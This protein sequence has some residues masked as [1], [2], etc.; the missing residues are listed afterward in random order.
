[1]SSERTS[2][3]FLVDRQPGTYIL[4]MLMAIAASHL[5]TNYAKVKRNR[6]Y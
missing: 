1:M 3:K 5:K 6:G 4:E 2:K